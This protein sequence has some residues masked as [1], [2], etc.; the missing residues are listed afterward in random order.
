MT[1]EKVRDFFGIKYLIPYNRTT[2][3][4]ICVL[5]VIGDINYES[6]SDKVELQGGHADAAWDTEYGQ[7]TI[8]LSGTLREYPAELFDLLETATITENGAETNGAVNNITNHQGTS[9]F[10]GANGISN[11][12]VNPSLKTSLI[13][14]QLTLVATGSTTLKLHAA[15]LTDTFLDIDGEI[16][17]SIST[18]SSGSVQ[19][20]AAGLVLTVVGTPNYTV[21]DTMAF[22]VRPVNSGSTRILVG[23]GDAPESFGLM[24]VFPRK[25]D[26][27]L[28]SI[29][30]FNVSGKG[31]PWKGVS[32]EFSE[33]D[34]DW[35]VAVRE[36]DNAIYELIRVLGS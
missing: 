32:R 4:P 17:T 20:S 31:L 18:T 15:G 26:G 2:K 27:V 8:G 3:K 21:G 1:I 16:V 36:E 33:F 5:R 19:I 24:C 10:G 23:S 14:G 28:H 25:S 22:D 13:F 11:V 7:P 34:F 12:T 35:S 30:V 9:I 29:N 6:S